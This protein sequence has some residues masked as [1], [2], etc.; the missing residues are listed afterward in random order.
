MATYRWYNV[1][2]VDD[3]KQYGDFDAYFKCKDMDISFD[4][5]VK[6][7][8]M[9]AIDLSDK[10]LSGT[11][12]LFTNMCAVVDSLKVLRY[13]YDKAMDANRHNNPPY[14]SSE[15]CG[16]F[17][18]R[19][20]YCYVDLYNQLSDD[21]YDDAYNLYASMKAASDAVVLSN[22]GCEVQTVF[23]V[24]H[25]KFPDKAYCVDEV[26]SSLHSLSY[27]HKLDCHLIVSDYDA[28]LNDN[29]IYYAPS[30]MA[31]DVVDYRL[32][33]DSEMFYDWRR[34][35]DES[36]RKYLNLPDEPEDDSE[37]EF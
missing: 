17:D 6:P 8:I 13:N 11:N 32:N 34:S 4:E 3:V 20:A 24:V 29:L 27:N 1:D 31:D 30:K 16:S 21:N 33:Q 19:V 7:R 36:S 28:I 26:F 14:E 5:Y 35:L 12:N 15:H 2:N 18:A 37:K 23:D 25:D 9:R 10:D 22:A